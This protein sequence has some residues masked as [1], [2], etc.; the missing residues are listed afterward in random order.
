MGHALLA[1][2]L[3]R[4]GEQQLARQHGHI[5]LQLGED[6]AAVIREVGT[7]AKKT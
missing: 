5:A 7:I 4:T 3:W 1:R 2:L 6:N